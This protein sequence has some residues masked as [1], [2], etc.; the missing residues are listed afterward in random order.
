VPV[1]IL[2]LG[3]VLSMQKNIAGP[4]LRVLCALVMTITFFVSLLL[5]QQPVT[6]TIRADQPG[7]K[8][9]PIFYGLMTEEIN[10]SY[11]GGLYAELI[12]NRTMRDNPQTP[13]N[14]SVVKYG[15]GEGVI[16]L[17]NNPVP[18]TA[19]TTALKLDASSL[20]GNQRVGVANEGYWGIPVRPDTTYRASFYAKAAGN[21]RGPLAVSIESNDAATVFAKADVAQISSE[22]KKYTAILKTGKSTA[23]TTNRFVISTGA[24]GV[25]S[26]NLVSL[27]PPTY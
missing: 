18:N 2:R 11:D 22:W 20:S 16:S 14:W 9:N 21:F 26:F 12:R 17:E 27:F 13:V 5:A 1:T 7:A 23:S 3:G 24:P 19:L 10:F 8:I 4:H 6:L 15:G 25:I